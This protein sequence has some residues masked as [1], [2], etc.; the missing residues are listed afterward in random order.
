MWGWIFFKVL[1]WGGGV[2]Q[3]K[4]SGEI[5]KNLQLGE[6]CYSEVCTAKAILPELPVYSLYELYTAAVS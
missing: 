4:M 3:M 1:S 2:Q 5:F 6:P